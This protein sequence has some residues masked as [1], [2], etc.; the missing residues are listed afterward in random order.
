MCTWT[1]E[2]L[3]VDGHGRGPGGWIRLNSAAVYYD[4]PVQGTADHVIV[5]DLWGDPGQPSAR[6][7]LELRASSAAELARAI[8]RTLMSPQAQRDLSESAAR[9]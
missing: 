6:V 3:T 4:H 9:I 1:S 8:D 2:R 7:A 5:I